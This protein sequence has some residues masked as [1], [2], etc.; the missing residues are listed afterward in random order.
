MLTNPTNTSNFSHISGSLLIATVSEVYRYGA[1]MWLFIV[2]YVIMGLLAIFIY[3]PVFFKV[4]MTN[5]Y[6][7]LE[8]RFDKRTRI[9]A[10]AIYLLSEIIMFPIMA[11]APS[12]TFAIGAKYGK[13]VIN[14]NREF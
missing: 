2:S 13:S 10:F 8:K 1:S 9:M 14:M 12:L 4:Q 7:Y 11:Y 6:E 5:I 3:L